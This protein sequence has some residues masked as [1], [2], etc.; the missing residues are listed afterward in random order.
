MEITAGFFENF[1]NPESV[2]SAS[3]FNIGCIQV[4]EAESEIKLV[5]EPTFTNLKHIMTIGKNGNI[6]FSK[7]KQIPPK[8][9]KKGAFSCFVGF[10]TTVET[11]FILFVKTVKRVR[12]EAHLIF[13]VQTLSALNLDTFQVDDDL[14]KA[15]TAV[16]SGASLFSYSMDL[17]NGDSYSH[18]IEAKIRALNPNFFFV[19]NL[20]AIEFSLISGDRGWLVPIIFGQVSKIIIDQSA[21]YTIYKES[22]L[23]YNPVVQEDLNM[24]SNFFCPTSMRVADV[25]LVQNE[26]LACHIRV[27]LNNFP[28]IIIKSERKGNNYF[29][30][31]YNA[32]RV[33]RYF[34]F[35]NEFF[36]CSQLLFFQCKRDD[37]RAA[38]HRHQD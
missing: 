34:Q 12:L 18:L 16:F 33:Y 30:L 7:S 23:D 25:L 32:N 15:L 38:G 36:K 17:S 4:M 13:Q 11:S 31:N 8:F 22:L 19:K 2:D 27:I 14:S 6:S 21:I 37:S 28:G 29:G 9:K 5:P 20:N 35:M 3:I 1:E 10:L 26:R 24:L